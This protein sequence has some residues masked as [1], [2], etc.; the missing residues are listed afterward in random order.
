MTIEENPVQSPDQ[1]KP[2]TWAMLCHLSALVGFMGVPFGNLLAP[3]IIWLVMKKEYPFVD[4]Q[5]K[6]ALNFQITMTFYAIGCALL[7]LVLIGFILIFVL[8]AV[9]VILVIIAGIKANNGESYRY[10]FTLRLIK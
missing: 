10:P 3:L 8:I 2:R 5:G 1:N 4:E 6:E 9:D 7:M